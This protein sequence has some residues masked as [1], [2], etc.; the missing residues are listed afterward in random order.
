MHVG[1]FGNRWEEA[2]STVL[3]TTNEQRPTLSINKVRTFSSTIPTSW[4]SRDSLSAIFLYMRCNLPTQMSCPSAPRPPPPG[5]ARPKALG[6]R[7][8]R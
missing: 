3:T 6:R 1:V 2:Q 7:I 8:C 5:P 4:P